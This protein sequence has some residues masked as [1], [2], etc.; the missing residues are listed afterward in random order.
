MNGNQIYTIT[1]IRASLYAGSRTPGFYH[2]FERAEQALKDNELDL[3]EA[4]YY[5]YAVIEEVYAGLYMFPRK[6]F[7]YK[8][9][10]EKECYESTDKPERF[11]KTFGWGIG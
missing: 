7:W 8:W 2:E 6:E 1:T 10:Q 3:N 4:G 5:P 9:N 11:K